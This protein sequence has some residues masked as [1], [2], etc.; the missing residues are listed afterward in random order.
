[1]LSSNAVSNSDTLC[2]YHLTK[3]DPIKVV[4]RSYLCCVSDAENYEL[5]GGFDQ[6]GSSSRIS[7]VINNLESSSMNRLFILR[8]S[9]VRFI[10]MQKLSAFSTWAKGRSS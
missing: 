3:S 8:R 7:R 6:V 4:S 1:M 2:V 5:Q 10:T 9:L